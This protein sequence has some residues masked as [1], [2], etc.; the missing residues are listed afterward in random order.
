MRTSGPTLS[1]EK[2]SG[3]TPKRDTRVCVAF[4]P[5]TPQMVA[6]RRMEPPVSLP[7]AAAKKRAA[8]PAPEPE[9]EP[10]VQY[11]GFHGLWQWPKCAL[12]PVG[13]CANSAMLSVPMSIAPAASSRRSTVAVAFGTKSRRMREPQVLTLPSR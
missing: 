2:E 13:F 6:G 3:I 1:A 11:A 10:P 12:W 8:T 5:V 4:S 9:E 7:S